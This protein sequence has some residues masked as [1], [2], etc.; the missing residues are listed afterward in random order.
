[1][2]ENKEA[3]G[4]DG[5]PAEVLKLIVEG[6][7][8]ILSCTITMPAYLKTWLYSASKLLQILLIHKSNGDPEASMSYRPLCILNTTG[9]FLER[10]L[11]KLLAKSITS[12]MAS[13][14]ASRCN[15]G[16][17]WGIGDNGGWQLLVVLLVTRQCFS[18]TGWTDNQRKLGHTFHI[19]SYLNDRDLL[20]DKLEGLLRISIAPGL[21]ETDPG[22]YHITS[23]WGMIH[24]WRLT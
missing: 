12:N 6:N 18:Y 20:Y 8:I 21:W 3:A 5:I 17:S 15:S 2:A 9:E 10:M 14:W 13:E 7:P 4:H 22:M 24:P 19:P 16:G 11:M 23:W 1:M